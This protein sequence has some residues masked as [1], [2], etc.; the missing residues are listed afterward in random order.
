MP[1]HVENYEPRSTARQVFSACA[2]DDM[3]ADFVYFGCGLHF[4]QLYPEKDVN[5]DKLGM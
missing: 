5:R 4:L 3:D 2:A 1:K